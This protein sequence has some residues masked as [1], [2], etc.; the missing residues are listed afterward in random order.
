M[1]NTGVLR[2]ADFILLYRI[3]GSMV[4]S[5]TH[6]RTSSRRRSSGVA[7]RTSLVATSGIPR[8]ARERDETA[9]E[10]LLGALEVASGSR[11]RAG[12]RR[13]DARNRSS[14][15]PARAGSSPSA[16]EHPAAPP[17]ASA[18]RPAACSS[19]SS[20][21]S[22]ALTLRRTQLAGRDEAAEIAIADAIG[23]E[24]IERG[25]AADRSR[26]R[27]QWR[28]DPRRARAANVRGAPSTPSRSPIR[29]RVV[30]EGRGAVDEILGER[31]APR[32]S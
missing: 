16:R 26:R 7:C 5:R 30:A 23:R 28:G 15:V 6:V 8:G 31:G 17:V 21:P 19:R 27:R 29:E 13:N 22:A 12:R 4:F 32:E 3:G 2:L 11:R 9:R 18:I 24:E 14:V 20:Q 25:R 1:T 10:S